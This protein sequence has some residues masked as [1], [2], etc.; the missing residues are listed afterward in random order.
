MTNN[1]SGINY[2][3][4]GAAAAQAED[5]TQMKEGGGGFERS[6]PEA[7]ICTLRLRQ[8][9]ETGSHKGNNPKYPKPSMQV[10]LRFEVNS[11]RHLIEY[12]DADG[13]TQKVPNTIDVYL[14][15]GGATSK[16]GR[17]FKALNYSGRFNHFAE[18]VGAGAWKATITHNKVGDKTYANLD[19]D[20]A[21]TFEAPTFQANDPE[22]G[23]P[24][25]EVKQIPVAEL[26]G[27]PQVFLWEN[28]GLT[29]EQ[30]LSLWDDI[31]I[32]GEYEAKDDKPAKSKNWI[33]EKIMAN[34]KYKGSRME[35]LVGA[36]AA[37]ELKA[38][39][40]QPI[41]GKPQTEVETTGTTDAAAQEPVVEQEEPVASAETTTVE[42]DEDPLAALG[43]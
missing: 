23:M 2:A 32:E 26:D 39:E 14:P 4:I 37:D 17:L 43:L 40:D 41:E 28:K 25:G 36:G 6:T 8:Y 12:D 30:Y 16:Y 35:K 27:D 19:K 5:Q 24:V 42:A 21:W 31:F 1:T 22:T 33:Q 11:K 13:N 10:M 15:K 29:D 18:M 7:G 38:L 9:I 20:G 34:L 3:E